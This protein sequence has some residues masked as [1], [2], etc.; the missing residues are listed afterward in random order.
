MDRQEEPQE[1]EEPRRT[2]RATRGWCGFKVHTIYPVEHHRP[3]RIRTSAVYFLTIVSNYIYRISSQKDWPPRAGRACGWP[4]AARRARTWTSARRGAPSASAAAATW[5]RAPRACPTS[6]PAPTAWPSTRPTSTTASSRR[7]CPRRLTIHPAALLQGLVGALNYHASRALASL[8]WGSVTDP[9]QRRQT[10]MLPAQHRPHVSAHVLLTAQGRSL[11]FS[12]GT[13]AAR[14]GHAQAELYAA[15]GASGGGKGGR[16]G[17]GTIAGITVGAALIAAAVGLA[18]YKLRLR[19]VMQARARPRS[20]R[21]ALPGTLRRG[22][23]RC[24][25]CKPVRPR[26]PRAAVSCR[27]IRAHADVERCLTLLAR[28][29]WC[30]AVRQIRRCSLHVA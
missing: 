25:C 13:E 16:V 4:A 15:L 28:P 12:A 5:T 26:N 8:V 24:C 22:R 20:A 19:H 9:M 29:G 10:G 21:P 18:V 11:R 30:A 27:L 23:E 17:A 2:G 6:A 14:P 1:Q 3:G 7:A